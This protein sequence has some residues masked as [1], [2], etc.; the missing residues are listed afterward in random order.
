[1]IWWVVL[2]SAAV[3]VGLLVLLDRGPLKVRQADLLV[4]LETLL[5]RGYDRGFVVIKPRRGRE[6]IQFT[7]Y[8][9]ESVAGIQFDFPRAPWSEAH[10]DRLQDLLRTAGFDFERQPTSKGAVSEFLV[11]DLKQDCERATDLA[12]LC[13]GGLFDSADS[14]L[15]RLRFHDVSPLQETN[16]SVKSSSEP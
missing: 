16:G 2:F 10:Y 4:Y 15:L 6:F 3:L 12:L 11:V 13:L 5:H 9:D 8:M 14:D 1:M 7:K